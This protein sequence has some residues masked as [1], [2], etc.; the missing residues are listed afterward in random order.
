LLRNDPVF[1]A[2][3]KTAEIRPDGCSYVI[4]PARPGQLVPVPQSAESRWG[5]IDFS[6]AG[7][8]LYRMISAEW[9]GPDWED[10]LSVSRGYYWEEHR[11]CEAEEGFQG[12]AQEY[13]AKG[14]VVRASRVK[15][16]GPWCVRWWDRFPSG[17]RL[18]LELGE[19]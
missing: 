1:L 17:Y 18:E 11:Y 4:D 9:L 14:E 10:D 8:I 16:I 6:P 3:P 13:L 12:I 5:E 2:V 7:A 19:P 15:P